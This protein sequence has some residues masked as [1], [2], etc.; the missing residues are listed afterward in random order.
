MRSFTHTIILNI[1][2][3]FSLEKMG[4]STDGYNTTLRMIEF[5]NIAR[6]YGDCVVLLLVHPGINILGRYLPPSKVNDLLLA[7]VTRTEP[8]AL[9]GDVSMIGNENSHL[10]DQM[11]AFDI[12]D[13]A[14]FLE[15]IILF[16]ACKM[17]HSIPINRFAI[18]AT[19]CLEA[20]HK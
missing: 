4:S 2:T 3:F 15:Y 7:D 1:L 16:F 11:E 5:C 19:R 20:L 9:H 6:E 12:M 8:T 13:L 14:S 17:M 18:Q 10:T